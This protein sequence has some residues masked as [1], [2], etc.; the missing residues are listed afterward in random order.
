MWGTEHEYFYS[1][2]F[3]DVVD[4]GIRYF[5]VIVSF[6]GLYE[7]GIGITEKTTSWDEVFVVAPFVYMIFLLGARWLEERTW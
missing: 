3:D 6:F 2:Q 4:D 5:M 7:I 1:N